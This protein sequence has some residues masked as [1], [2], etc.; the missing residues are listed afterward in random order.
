MDKRT[1]YISWDEYFMGVAYL[2]AMRSKDPH[3]Q[4]GAKIIRFCPSDIMDFQKDVPM[5]TFRGQ[6]KAMIH[7][8][9]NISIQHT[10]NS[11]P[12]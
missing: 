7:M 12:S 5:K 4:V 6:E 10:A 3:T 9:Q 11:M 1:D 8:I 2:A